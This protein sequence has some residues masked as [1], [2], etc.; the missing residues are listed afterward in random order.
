MFH[1][2]KVDGVVQE[3]KDKGSMKEAFLIF[4]ASFILSA[5]I[6]VGVNA[7]NIYIFEYEYNSLVA[8]GVTMDDPGISW[9]MLGN[10]ILAQ[11]I[12]FVPF[13]ILLSTAS[14]GITFYLF[15]FTGGKG[16]F[17]Q[18]YYLAALVS[19]SAI[20]ASTVGFLLILPCI[21]IIVVFA[22]AIISLYYALFVGVKAYQI[23][24]DVTYL[25][26]FVISVV[27][28]IIRTGILTIIMKGVATIFGLPDV[29]GI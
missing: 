18:Q 29:P 10:I 11:F 25:H 5:L 19:L 15:R 13:G 9:D 7:L 27:M 23:I 12:F 28:L 8:D 16:Q 20:M 24:H 2:N 17:K 6:L 21:K 14:E 26:A 3:E 1:Y 22:L 4:L